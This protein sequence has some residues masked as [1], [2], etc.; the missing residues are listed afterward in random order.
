MI[1]FFRRNY[2]YPISLKLLTLL[3]G[4]LHF[5]ERFFN[6]NISTDSFASITRDV[7]STTLFQSLVA[8]KRGGGTLDLSCICLSVS[9]VEKW[10][11]S[12]TRTEC[13][14]Y[15]PLLC[16]SMEKRLNDLLR[17]KPPRLLQWEWLQT[18]PPPNDL[19][20]ND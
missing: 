2:Q 12:M 9:W 19:F 20:F 17:P 4:H 14:K 10:I 13:I 3:F 15:L 18:H 5:D 6:Q 1:F 16:V 8:S 7:I 11:F